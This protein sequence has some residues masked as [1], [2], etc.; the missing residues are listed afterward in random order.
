L[1][2]PPKKS[3]STNALSLAPESS[4]VSALNQSENCAWKS[5]SALPRRRRRPGSW[6]QVEQSTGAAVGDLAVGG[7]GDHRVELDVATVRER[8]ARVRARGD[9]RGLYRLAR[10][11]GGRGGDRGLRL[12]GLHFADRGLLLLL[13]R[14][15]LLY[16]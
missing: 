15:Q 1:L 5:V 8:R 9:R 3:I 4:V 7:V 6:R 12:R 2:P 11:G 13:L 16:Q 10:C 14:H